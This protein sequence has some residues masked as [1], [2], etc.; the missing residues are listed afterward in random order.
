MRQEV[1]HHVHHV[2]RRL[3][4][5]HRDVDVH[6]EDQQRTRKLLQLF[7]D[8]FV[9]L[10][11]RDDLVDPAGEGMRSGGDDLEVGDLLGLR[12]SVRRACD[13]SRCAILAT[14]SQIFE[15]GST[16]DWCISCLTCST[17]SGEVA[18]TS[19]MTCERSSIVAGSMI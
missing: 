13:A 8:V 10:A 7:D 2:D 5:G 19:C 12:R 6:A 9:A 4:V 11:G 3:L 14:L 16:I 17:M 18:D 1:A 15:P